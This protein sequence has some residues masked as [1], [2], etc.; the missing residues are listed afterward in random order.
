MNISQFVEYLRGSATWRAS[1]VAWRVMPG[2]EARYAP[3]PSV[4]PALVEA[5][6]GRGVDRLYTHQ[7]E[8]FQH[9][10][11]G[12]HVVVVTPT[13]S[14]K[15]LCYNLPVLDALLRDPE[16]R[17]LY[18]FPTKALAQDQLAELQT[19][20]DRLPPSVRVFTYDGDTP[21]SARR[22]VRL[23]G[24]VIMT[25]PD[26][27]HTA[28][29]PQHGK[30]HQLF[31][32]LKYVVVD[33]LHTYRGV[34]GSH[35]A[36]VLRRL[37][38]VCAFYGTRPQ[39]ICT[40]ATIANP[41]ELAE[42]LLEERVALV[43]DNGA[44]QGERHVVFLNPP[45]VNES[46]GIRASAIL[47]AR[48][49]VRELL[50][51][52]IPTIVFCRSRLTVEVLVTYLREEAQ[53]Y[54]LPSE[55]VRGYRGG[56][57]PNERRAIERGLR[58][59]EV[60]CVVSTN[61]LELGI[62]IGSLQACVIVGYPGTLAST[63]QQFGRVGRRDG[64]SLCVLLGMSTPLDQ[65]LM[66]HPEYVFDRSVE[67]GLVS[68]NNLYILGSHLKCAAFELPF[69]EGERFGVDATE[70][71]LDH[72]VSERVL[73][74][75]GGRWY[76][77]AES[78][79]AHQVSL[80]SATVDNFVIIDTTQPGQPR[81]IGEMD[82]IS[83]PTMLHEEA[84]YLHEG[85]QYQV[86][87][88][89]WSEKKAYVRAVDV[90]YYTDANLAV[91][92]QVLDTL[93]QREEP[94]GS[95]AWGEVAL[96]FRATIF[97]KIKFDTHENVGWGEIHLPEETIHTTAWWIGLAPTLT[98]PLTRDELEDGLL[99]L[100]HVVA[101]VAPLYLMCDP[102]DLG[103]HVELRSPI[104]QVPTVFVYDKAPG[105]VGLA[106]RLFHTTGD[107]L[108]AARSLVAECRCDDGCPACVGVR[109]E[110]GGMAKQVVRRL[111]GA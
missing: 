100:G 62:D 37:K 47:F 75:A 43:D 65:F 5:L 44:P 93:E 40:S 70:Q 45:M 46:L 21:V 109:Q 26:M 103:V 30:W 49:L 2:R 94:W 9:A 54:G 71:L 67:S 24:N 25:N 107:V 13:A 101:N 60:S 99:G 12:N 98:A 50:L 80:R 29:L 15:T 64:P 88:L 111:L 38:R 82:R 33:E 87:R 85:R 52:G 7:A 42:K 22:S 23:R 68:P 39:F 53:R 76:W 51:Q 110:V 89:D 8:A 17:V 106:E 6:R 72:L 86:E 34:F 92:L 104:I 59:G 14:G 32:R 84:I 102:R 79:P 20:A 16:A 74:R 3:F 97:K 91:R 41:R 73:H 10:R 18:L 19:L 28:I 108:A 77:S 36:N 48:D 96:T 78:F 4:E 31:S 83:V 63:W 56:Y 58:S 90:D 66:A 81:V 35:M 55:T 105:G 57:L 27:L 1:I 95:K 11:E 69:V 61:A